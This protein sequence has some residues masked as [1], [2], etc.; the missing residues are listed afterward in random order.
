MGL[1]SSDWQ[2]ITSMP[3]DRWF[4]P[5]SYCWICWKLTPTFRQGLLTYA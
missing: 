4:I 3:A 1:T 2:I 5:F